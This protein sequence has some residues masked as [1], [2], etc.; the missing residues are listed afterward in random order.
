MGREGGNSIGS[1]LKFLLN[2]LYIS[3]NEQ[4]FTDEYVLDATKHLVDSDS[5]YQR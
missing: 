3:A 2:I 1:Q 5:K 4:Q